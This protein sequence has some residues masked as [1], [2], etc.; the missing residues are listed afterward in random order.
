MCMA[1]GALNDAVAWCVSFVSIPF[2]SEAVA[3]IVHQAV[4]VDQEIRP[5]CVF[6]KAVRNANSI[7]MYAC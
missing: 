7:D 2:A 1:G 6:R 4:N 3:D 5:Q